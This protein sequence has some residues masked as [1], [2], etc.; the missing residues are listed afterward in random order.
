MFYIYFY[1]HFDVNTYFIHTL[2]FNK[3][4]KVNITIINTHNLNTCYIINIIDYFLLD[5]FIFKLGSCSYIYYYVKNIALYLIFF[6]IVNKW[7]IT[8]NIR[9]N[10]PN[11]IKHGI[12]T[13]INISIKYFYSEYNNCYLVLY[14]LCSDEIRHVYVHS[15]YFI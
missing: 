13:D 14:K 11:V 5:F 7:P 12:L 3:H 9:N 15:G 4:N 2:L 8:K 10:K 6:F 1:V